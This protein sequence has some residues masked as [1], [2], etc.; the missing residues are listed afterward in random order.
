[1]F[2][3]DKLLLIFYVALSVKLQLLELNFFGVVKG[4]ALK[5]I[6]S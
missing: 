6:C 2:C 1:M 4:Y 5:F 3:F